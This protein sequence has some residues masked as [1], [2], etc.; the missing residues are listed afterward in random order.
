MLDRVDNAGIKEAIFLRLGQGL[1]YKR[2][3]RLVLR[4]Y[5]LIDVT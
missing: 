3:L 2:A 5:R 1:G 4:L